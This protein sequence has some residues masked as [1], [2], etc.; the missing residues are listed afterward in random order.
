ML[1]NISSQQYTIQPKHN[2]QG[3][4]VT[5]SLNWS[6][7][8]FLKL[9][10]ELRDYIYRLAVRPERGTLV[11][12][13]SREQFF[14]QPP[15]SHH[16]CHPRFHNNESMQTNL[17]ALLRVSRQIYFE[18]V[19]PVYEECTFAIEESGTMKEFVKMLGPRISYLR[20]FVIGIRS[21]PHSSP[22]ECGVYHVNN[23]LEALSKA[24]NLKDV[25]IEDLGCSERPPGTAPEC[26][27]I[28]KTYFAHISSTLASI[29]RAR[30]DVYEMINT[31]SFYHRLPENENQ[32]QDEET[33]SREVYRPVLREKMR[34]RLEAFPTL[35]L[36]T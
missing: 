2:S 8:P 25:M 34:K 4:T 22:H 30:G 12:I 27:D 29:G 3:L 14:L 31:L 15:R 19:R 21:C 5:L 1:T 18:A 26:F 28:F 35:G 7:F 20:R 32:R 36:L 17:A 16:L 23:C 6:T 11:R 9:P 24:D 13:E 10:P 33:H